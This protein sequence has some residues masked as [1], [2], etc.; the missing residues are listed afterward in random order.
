MEDIQYKVNIHPLAHA[1]EDER[2]IVQTILK[3]PVRVRRKVLDEIMFIVMSDGLVG[4]TEELS[5]LKDKECIVFLNFAMM[6]KW[7]RH[8]RMTG[9]AHEIAH[10]I[11]GHAAPLNRPKSS[12][13]AEVER[14]ADDLFEKWGF[15]RVYKNY[16]W[17]EFGKID[18][19]SFCGNSST[20]R[21]VGI[22]T[23]RI[24]HRYH[25][26]RRRVAEEKDQSRIVA[27]ATG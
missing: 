2:L 18:R 23:Q 6:K 27:V 14:K 5:F 13:E 16:H 24:I 4:T 1:V 9:I 21:A 8:K 3:L 7:S 11:L 19:G 10:I 26:S 25:G 20:A 12:E 22:M 17:N 15:S